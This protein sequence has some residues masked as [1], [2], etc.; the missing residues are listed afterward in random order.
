M[1]EAEYTEDMT[2]ESSDIDARAIRSIK[3]PER[4]YLNKISQVNSRNAKSYQNCTSSWWDFKESTSRTVDPKKGKIKAYN[5]L[6]NLLKIKTKLVAAP[7]I[8]GAVANAIAAD[9]AAVSVAVAAIAEYTNSA[10][11]YY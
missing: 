4:I 7:Q 5:R 2:T 1:Q 11:S 8:D 9:D 6:Q 3:S 10:R